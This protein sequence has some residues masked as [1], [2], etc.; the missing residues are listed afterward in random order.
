M[1][2]SMMMLILSIKG[3]RTNGWLLGNLKSDFYA[4]AGLLGRVLVSLEA[5]GFLGSLITISPAMF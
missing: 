2:T 5:L 3:I 1:G 4:F